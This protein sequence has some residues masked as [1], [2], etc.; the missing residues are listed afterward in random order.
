MGEGV[1]DHVT[2]A[3]ALHPII[4]NGSGGLHCCFHIA[5]LDEFPFLLRVIRPHAGQTI[6]LQPPAHII[7]QRLAVA[8]PRDRYLTITS[9]AR[10]S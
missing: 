10:G 8:K 5:G 7:A 9:A 2:L 4:T 6:S 3:L 1:R